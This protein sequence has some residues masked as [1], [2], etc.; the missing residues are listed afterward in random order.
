MAS[1]TPSQTIGPF[2]AEGLR[3][4]VTATTRVARGDEVTIEG[5]VLDAD[6]N[7]VTDALVEAWQPAASGEALGGLQRVATDVGGGFRFHVARD[8]VRVNVVLLARGLLKAACTR[9]HLAVD[10]VPAAVP[11]ARAHTLVA[12]PTIDPV[13]FSWDI[14][15]GGENETVFFEL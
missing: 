5:R 10:D 11:P 14:R 4:A 3:W 6:G 15:L 2:F 7:P 1:P 13:R 8:T 9:L 12:R